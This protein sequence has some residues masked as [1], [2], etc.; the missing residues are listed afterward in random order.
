MFIRKRQVEKLMNAIWKQLDAPGLLLS[1]I[2]EKLWF[3]LLSQNVAHP[4]GFPKF[5][6]LAHRRQ[7]GLYLFHVGFAVS[8]ARIGDKRL[9][10]LPD[11]Q[12]VGA[13]VKDMYY[14]AFEIYR[15]LVSH[16]CRCQFAVE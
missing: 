12:C 13:Q 11:D 4:D 7:K 15:A 6:V 2:V 14:F 3:Q 1:G 9:F 16:G 10:D 8:K 5:T